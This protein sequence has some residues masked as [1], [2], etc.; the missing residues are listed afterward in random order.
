MSGQ[1]GRNFGRYGD[2]GMVALAEISYCRFVVR[3][4]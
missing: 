3:E 1:I 2:K 4:W